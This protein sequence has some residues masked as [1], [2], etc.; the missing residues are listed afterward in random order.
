MTKFD[1]VDVFFKVY[2]GIA[3]VVAFIMPIAGTI[4]LIYEHSI[5]NL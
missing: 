4:L 2:E 5:G 3:R 1:F